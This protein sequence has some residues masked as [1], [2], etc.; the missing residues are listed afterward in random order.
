MTT[1]GIFIVEA[2]IGIGLIGF[3]WQISS[4]L[5]SLTTAVEHVGD[6]TEDH[7]DRIRHLEHAA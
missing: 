6:I 1:V 7:E 4:Q 2:V 3:L 5:G